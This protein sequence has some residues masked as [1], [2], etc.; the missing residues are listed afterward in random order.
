V[1]VPDCNVKAGDPLIVL[2]PDGSGRALTVTVPDGCTAG[3]VFLVD[4]TLYSPVRG[5]PVSKSIVPS[6][7]VVIGMNQS[8]Q[9]EKDLELNEES[10]VNT[11]DN[12]IYLV[13]VPEGTKP[14]EKIQVSLPDKSLIEVIVPD[15]NG[16][17]F[18]VRSP[19]KTPGWHYTSPVPTREEMH[20]IV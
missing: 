10:N 3:H 16:E 15:G 9:P 14:G 13:M 6:I 20:Q 7:A 5:I 12:G 11:K 18:Y 4:F 8:Q 19:P 17:K 1:T 2:A